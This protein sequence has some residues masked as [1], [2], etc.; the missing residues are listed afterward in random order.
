MKNKG[1][2]T[3]N[4]RQ[5]QLKPTAELTTPA[6]TSTSTEQQ[7][8]HQRR[9]P[10]EEQSNPQISA[11]SVKD[12]T[13]SR[14]DSSA[15]LSSVPHKNIRGGGYHSRKY[16][17][18]EERWNQNHV[19]LVVRS[20]DMTPKQREK[21]MILKEKVKDVDHYM[22]CPHQLVYFLR[23]E[24]GNVDE[25]EKW[26]R[27]HVEYRIN[28]PYHMNNIL[29]DYVMPDDYDYFPMAVCKGTDKEGNP[30]QITRTGA[31]DC[32]GLF[33]RHG[34]DVMI[35][36]SVYNQEL[37]TRGA[38]IDDYEAMYNRKPTKFTVI[39]DL[40]GLSSQHMRPGLLPVCGTVARIL[41]DNYPEIVRR[42]IV[43]RAPYLFKTIW[44]LVKHFFDP[45]LRDLMIFGT[46]EANSEEVLDQY[47]DRD[48]LPHCIHPLGKDGPLARG[49]AHVKMN[50]GTIP[51]E[52]EYKTPPELLGAGRSHPDQSTNE[53]IS[54]M[55]KTM[56]ASNT[57]R[58]TSDVKLK[59]KCVNLMSGS[60][61]FVHTTEITAK[62]NT[63]AH[64]F[65]TLVT[66]D[67]H[68]VGLN[69]KYQN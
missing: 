45:E 10:C 22:N 53:S 31:A 21:L 18:Y 6:K 65:Q 58:A 12:A 43:I 9:V 42:V 41:Q 54:D 17:S 26:F 3:N 8:Q 15:T 5:P 20:W 29:E 64:D 55:S 32:W 61:D 25:A 68:L 63:L 13:S 36:H 28:S 66:I 39:F 51:A 59:P 35:H 57:R 24:L 52:G 1:K 30:I 19:D 50:G 44:G 2:G 23:D 69:G 56:L 49:Y 27:K 34:R 11:S 33:R 16:H 48:V 14:T 37:E 47:I 4:K 38:W 67:R 46:S 40:Q 60:F 62:A 7:Q